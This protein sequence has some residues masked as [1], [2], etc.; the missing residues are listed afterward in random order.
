MV[1]ILTRSKANPKS[2][3]ITRHC[4]WESDVFIGYIF[5][6]AGRKEREGDRTRERERDFID[7]CIFKDRSQHAQTSCFPSFLPSLPLNL[8]ILFCCFQWSRRW[9]L[10]LILV[11]TFHQSLSLGNLVFGQ[12][13]IKCYFDLCWHMR[14][15]WSAL[16][17]RWLA[18]LRHFYVSCH[19][20]VKYC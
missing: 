1:S 9:C 11:L 4:H 12:L 15:P 14:L 20:T 17:V 2:I 13:L 3:M 18:E 8:S 6:K 5:F 10:G 16:K 19:N 7:H